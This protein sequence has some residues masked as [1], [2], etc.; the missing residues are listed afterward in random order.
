ML[1]DA[2]KNQTYQNYE[3]IVV[4]D[5]VS[6]QKIVKDY[7]EDEGINVAYAGP[8]K[9]PCFPELGYNVLN[10]WNT[11]ALKSIGDI[12]V[13]MCDY[14][15]YPPNSLEKWLKWE[16][17]FKENNCVVCGGDMYK[18]DRK[19]DFQG[20]ITLWDPP[21][22]G[23]A[24][25]NDCT[26]EFPWMPEYFEMAYT[27]YPYSLL[28]AMNGLPE[29]CDA[30]AS[31]GQFAPMIDKLV[32]VGGNIITDPENKMQMI[33]HRLWEPVQL[34]HQGKRS[35]SGSTTYIPRENCFNM[36]EHVRGDLS[37]WKRY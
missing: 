23:N 27:A 32:S 11:G 21:W 5:M 24:M 34:W 18:E 1:A 25:E 36:K 30:F 7:L 29:S 17:K 19:K 15:W 33:N 6:R 10:A 14:Q 13:Y 2:L 28:E 31:D 16:E 35:P 20:L 8:S 22:K 12:V 4:D 9:K 26:L 3:L 37:R